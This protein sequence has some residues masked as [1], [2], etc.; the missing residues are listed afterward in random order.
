MD[1]SPRLL[2]KQPK[3]LRVL[4]W[5]HLSPNKSV[6]VLLGIK[7]TEICSGIV[8]RNKKWSSKHTKSMLHTVILLLKSMIAEIL[9]QLC[10]VINAALSVYFYTHIMKSLHHVWISPMVLIF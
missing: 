2:F 3:M 6:P 8:I 1:S 5:R 4:P 7:T 10:F 9:T